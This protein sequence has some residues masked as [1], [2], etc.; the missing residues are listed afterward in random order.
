MKY[1]IKN[2]KCFAKE[3]TLIFILFIFCEFAA[4]FI[5]FLS[6]GTYQNFKL[7]KNSDIHKS[8]IVIGFGNVVDETKFNDEVFFEGDGS[9]DNSDVKKFLSLLSDDTL[10]EIDSVVYSVLVYD[11]TGN[12]NFGGEPLG[13]CFRLEYSQNDK[14]FVPYDTAFNNSPV[15]YGKGMSLEDYNSGEKNMVLPYYY[16]DEYIG[17][18]MLING[19][20]YNIIGVDSVD[21][22]AVI[23][24]IN[25]PDSLGNISNIYFMTN[26]VISQTAYNDI[27]TSLKEVFGDYAFIPEVDTISTKLPFYNSIM[28]ISVILTCLAAITLSLLFRYILSTRSRTISILRICG[29]TNLKVRRIFISEV[30]LTSLVSFF[31]TVIIYFKIATNELKGSL[32]YI[33]IVYSL[34]NC[35]ILSVV[36]F[37]CI[38]IVLKIMIFIT[39]LKTPVTQIKQ[40]G[41]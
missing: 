34:K 5:L 24:Y 39:L 19:E 28:L 40:G 31:I 2:L 18:E 10:N 21:D 16:S 32:V 6:F 13:I 11:Y 23:P 15:L 12:E 38:Y 3:N 29:C 35:A 37:L 30:M 25:S 14:K 4:A 17:Q 33:D 9:V 7:V 1:T 20:S 26:N 22:F 36:Y 27:K 41:N 8:D